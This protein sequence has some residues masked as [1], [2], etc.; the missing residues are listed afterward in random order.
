MRCY[1][2]SS[3]S[4]IDSVKVRYN[5]MSTFNYYAGTVWKTLMAS[6]WVPGIIYHLM[7]PFDMLSGILIMLNARHDENFLFIIGASIF[8]KGLA[9]IAIRSCRH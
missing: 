4:G 2:C 8:V 5:T 1:F 6:I 3:N 9:L 7:I